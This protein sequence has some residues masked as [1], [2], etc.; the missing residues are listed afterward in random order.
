MLTD[1]DF[2][3]YLA[4]R[5]K[6]NELIH[7]H[8]LF[9]A[10]NDGSCGESIVGVSKEQVLMSV[11]TVALAWFSTVVDKNGL[12]IFNLWLKMYPQYQKR[13]AFYRSLLEPHLVL[14]RTFRDRTAF[15]AQPTFLKFF[16]PRVRFLEKVKDVAKA[17][18]K[19]LDLAKFLV[20]REHKCDP[21]FY[22][23][24]LDVVFDTELELKCKINRRWLIEANILDRSSFY[25]IKSFR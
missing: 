16:E 7:L 24:T 25:G 1:K 13:I 4:Y 9:H 19:L 21:D 15:H 2:G 10:L 5:F 3:N 14:I 22:A 23:R 12:D 8:L 6:L 20:K 17:V 11:R 18:Q